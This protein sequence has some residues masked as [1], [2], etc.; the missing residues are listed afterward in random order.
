[1]NDDDFEL[2]GDTMRHLE[3]LAHAPGELRFRIT[4]VQAIKDLRREVA[5]LTTVLNDR[6]R[7]LEERKLI[8]EL[9]V[10]QIAKTEIK[11]D[12][13]IA[14]MQQDVKRLWAGAVWLIAIMG[15][16]VLGA[17]VHAWFK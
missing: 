8:G 1:V 17:A 2:N 5:L 4:L 7:K 9:K 11:A 10:A 12:A 13:S 6:M 15:A 3:T 14:R 16:G